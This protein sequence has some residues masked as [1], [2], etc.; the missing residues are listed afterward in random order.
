MWVKSHDFINARE[1]IYLY[2]YLPA[3]SIFIKVNFKIIKIPF[4]Y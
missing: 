3:I 2:V 4:K 1:S